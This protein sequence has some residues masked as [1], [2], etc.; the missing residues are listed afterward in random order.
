[1]TDE[2]DFSGFSIEAA[3]RPTL[4]ESQQE[5]VM[6][7]DGNAVVLAVAGAGKTTAMIHRAF[8]LIDDGTTSGERILML[9]FAKDAAEN[10]RSR[11]DAM[12]TN[13]GVDARTIHS[14]CFRLLRRFDSRFSA[15]DPI[16][17][18]SQD[19]LIGSWLKKAQLA[20]GIGGRVSDA[21][22]MLT[23]VYA[24]GLCPDRIDQ[25]NDELYPHDLHDAL[26]LVKEFWNIRHKEGNKQFHQSE[27]VVYALD[28]LRRDE[29]ARKYAQAEYSH[30]IIDEYQDVD[31]GQERIFEIIGGC[32]NPSFYFKESSTP[33][34]VTVVGDDDQ[35][36]YS[37]RGA[38]AKL[39]IN[40]AAK[41][42]AKTFR[43]EENFRSQEQILVSA[44]ALIKNN[45]VRAK[46]EL[47]GTRGANGEIII[48]NH[49]LPSALM[50]VLKA[51][52]E[53][54][55]PWSDMCIAVRTN[56]QAGEFETALSDAEIP[57]IPNTEGEGYFG[58]QEIKPFVCYARLA[59]D[60]KHFPSLQYIWN[61]P[62]RFLRNDWVMAM[63]DDVRTQGAITAV[64]QFA[65]VT[66][67][68]R[69]AVALINAL[70]GLSAFY[71]KEQRVGPILRYI[72]QAINCNTLLEEISERGTRTYED[73]RESVN[74]LIEVAGT[75]K[76][77]DWLRLVDR[78]IANSQKRV[79][80]GVK[81][82]TVHRTKGLEFQVM[83]LGNFCEG[84]MPHEA[85]D[86]DDERRLAYVGVTRAKKILILQSMHLV[87]SH[88]LLEMGL[89]NPIDNHQ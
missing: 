38:E 68:A 5:V 74:R 12:M 50:P 45:Q 22:Q 55:V 39:L 35:T 70:K 8:S 11:L 75:K 6:H 83:V 26:T 56:A 24:K 20:T 60:P 30:L 29:M 2:F 15:K 82:S 19:W 47:R 25:T 87:D 53:A 72:S 44:N 89:K 84:S 21:R 13:H 10:M 40:F 54:G 18:S 7:R 69:G 79:I 23:S 77:P 64:E 48:L 17:S 71:L 78:T 67:G 41:W 73:L 36:T 80:D 46:K 88:F 65:Q 9:T 49:T 28:L 59:H 27:L 16:I 66:T 1:M 61:K 57:F 86:L 42:N 33:A 37:F 31:I 51:H 76:L 63:I 85:G 58:M 81:V 4:T 62:S 3:T 32:P 34:Q 14:Y 43:M 52:H